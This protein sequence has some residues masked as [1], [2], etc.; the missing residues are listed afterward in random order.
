LRV[1]LKHR[2]SLKWVQIP[3]KSLFFAIPSQATAVE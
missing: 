2:Y 1:K 3:A